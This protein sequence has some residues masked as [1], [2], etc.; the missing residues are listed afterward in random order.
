MKLFR[1][2]LVVED[3]VKFWK[4]R[5]PRLLPDTDWQIQFVSTVDKAKQTFQDDCNFDLLIV[6]YQLNSGTGQEFLEFVRKIDVNIP[7]LIFSDEPSNKT[8]DIRDVET[9]KTLPFIDKNNCLANPEKA[10]AIIKAEYEKYMAVMCTP[11][12]QS[13]YGQLR[14]VLVHT[15]FE[16]MEQIEPNDPWYLIDSRPALHLAQEQH[17]GFIK[18]IKENSLRPIVLD[19]GLLLYDVLK[20]LKGWELQQVVENILF[21]HGFQILTKRCA[22]YNLELSPLLREKVDEICS[23]DPQTITKVLLCGLNIADLLGEDAEHPMRKQRDCQIIAPVP[24]LY[25]MR[26][27]GF[28][29]G[30]SFVLSRM[31]W[32]VRRREPSILHT[33]LNYHPFFKNAKSQAIDWNLDSGEE[34]F[35]E[36]GDVMA[37]SPNNYAIA[38]SERTSRQAVRKVAFELLKRGAE[39][40]F[41]PTIPVKRAFIHLDTVCSIVGPDYVVAHPEAVKAYANTLCWTHKTFESNDEPESINTDFI[42]VLQNHFNKKIIEVTDPSEQ[43]DD[44]VNV[45]MIKPDTAVAY[46]RN[47]KANKALRKHG[48]QVIEFSGS[49]LVVGRGGARCM[50]MPIR[51]D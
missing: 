26:D 22:K 44:A 15:P 16:E 23:N 1:R 30:E 42:R 39:R 37:I 8:F 28:V 24:N 38:L 7:I 6:D 12:I 19:I 40:I 25:F 13:E 35:I 21:S 2:V 10:A 11:Q 5:I 47:P 18:A 3:D 33:V 9:Y 4:S 17:I 41:Q 20:S 45:L 51:R 14:T 46:D 31:Y 50:T 48:I 49:D 34:F 36:G 27:P 29:L 43:F 32:N